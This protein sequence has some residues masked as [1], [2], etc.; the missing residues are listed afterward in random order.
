[1][2]V[3]AVL[4]AV[5]IP[6]GALAATTPFDSSGTYTVPANVTIVTAEVIGG[7]GGGGGGAAL[8]GGGGGG[9]GQVNNYY[10][11]VVPGDVCTFTV[12]QGGA[13]GPAGTTGTAGGA[14]FIECHNGFG[15]AQGGGGGGGATTG[16]GG[17]G[18]AGGIVSGT[19]GSPGSTAPNCATSAPG[20]AGGGSGPGAGGAGGDG[21]CTQG[22]AGTAGTGGRVTITDVPSP[23]LSVDKTAS[24]SSRPAPGGA[25]TFTIAVH[26]TSTVQVDITSI[27]DDIYGNVGSGGQ[28]AN[29]CPA[30]IGAGLAPD[31][32][33]TCSFTGNFTGTAGSAQTDIATV[34]ARDAYTRVASDDDAAT[35]TLTPACTRTV[36]GYVP[37]AVS[38]RSGE[39]VCFENATVGG[40]VTV[41]P[42]GSFRSTASTFSGAITSTGAQ[43]FRLCGST[44]GGSVKVQNS[45]GPVR[46]GDDDDDC[47]SSTLRS[48]LTVSGN[49]GGYEVTGNQIA[50]T[51]T[52][53]NNTS[54]PGEESE[55]KNNRIS[56]SLNCSGNTP[57]PTGGGNTTSGA[58]TGQCTL[59]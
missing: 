19:A 32:T 25:F 23:T 4:G 54:D 58:K 14:T 47:A 22:S 39:V 35:V 36:T 48:G 9:S 17:T 33:L 3:S 37:G 16:V 51:T 49:T 42:G 50:G 5:L 26:N 45:T 12:G 46:I 38:I 2:L 31:Q 53:V 27:T 1:V 30:L 29:T 52:I 7:G 6:S 18:G 8:A 56:P 34:Q 57:P 40:A 44:V 28:T 55:V 59:L 41:Q 21:G 20:G 24:P 11:P 43:E 10:F 15:T 13:P